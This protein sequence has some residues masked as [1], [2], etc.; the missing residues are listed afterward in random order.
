MEE[1]IL[2]GLSPEKGVLCVILE[3]TCDNR[4]ETSKHRRGNKHQLC[5]DCNVSVVRRLSGGLS[6]RREREFYFHNQ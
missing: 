2:N 4:G 3:P 6:R 5:L 1:Y